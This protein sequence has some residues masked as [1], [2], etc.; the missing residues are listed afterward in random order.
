MPGLWMSGLGDSSLANWARILV[1]EPLLDAVNMV[2][3][4]AIQ[5]SHLFICFQLFLHAMCDGL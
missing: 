1:R 2:A 5:L 4:S 3:M